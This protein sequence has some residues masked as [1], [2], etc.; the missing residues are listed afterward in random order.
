MIQEL[1]GSNCHSKSEK[2]RGNILPLD[3]EIIKHDMGANAKR[4]EF[5]D[6]H[7]TR[8]KDSGST[9]DNGIINLRHLSP[10]REKQYTTW[11]I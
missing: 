2:T 6:A 5:E 9:I 10:L 7:S 3:Y 8:A 4:R 11:R 1:V